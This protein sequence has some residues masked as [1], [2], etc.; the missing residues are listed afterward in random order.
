MRYITGKK[1]L[2]NQL[3]SVTHY[4]TGLIVLRIEL[5]EMRPRGGALCN[6]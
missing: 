3:R 2:G 6:T 5:V 4:M 1:G